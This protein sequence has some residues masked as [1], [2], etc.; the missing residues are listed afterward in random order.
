[1]LPLPCPSTF[2]FRTIYFYFSAIPTDLTIEVLLTSDAM[3]ERV[4]DAFFGQSRLGQYS[5]CRRWY[6]CQVIWTTLHYTTRHEHN[7]TVCTPDLWQHPASRQCQIILADP[8]RIQ[9]TPQTAFE[10]EC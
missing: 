8:I 7:T 10:V 3:G 1:M 4:K 6:E 2:S 5:V 9:N